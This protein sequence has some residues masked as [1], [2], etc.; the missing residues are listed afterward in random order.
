LWYPLYKSTVLGDDGSG[1]K[2]L[3]TEWGITGEMGEMGDD[4]FL[5]LRLFLSDLI[6]LERVL[7]SKLPGKLPNGFKVK[8]RSS[9][10]TLI[11]PGRVKDNSLLGA[12][13]LLS[14]GSD[15]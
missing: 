4:I 13:P 7:L 14:N 12:S 8:L 10:T 2:T 9:S 5:E 15:T 3:V 6:E 11:G 1:S